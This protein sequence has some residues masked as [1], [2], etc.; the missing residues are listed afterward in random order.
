[1][2]THAA[3]PG[4][5]CESPATVFVNSAAGGGRALVYL[6]RIQK[7]FESFSISAQF[8]ATNSVAELEASAQNAILRGRRILFAMGGDGTFQ[9]LANA[10]FGSDVLLGVLPSG[11]GNDFAAAIGL[12]EDFLEA[13]EA[14]L[15]GEP[16]SVDLLKVRTAEGRTRLYVGG[17]GIGLDAEAAR[18]ASGAYRR[19][20]GRMRYIASALRALVWFTPL[21]IH[22]EF[23]E[24]DLFEQDTKVLLG[25]ALNTPTYG[26]GLRLAPGAAVDD[27]LMHVVLIEDIG[28]LGILRLLPRLM[29]S[30]ELRTSRVKRWHVKKARFTT[31]EPC[32]FHADGEIIGSTPVDIEVVPRA[33]QVLAPK[34]K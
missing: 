14:I 31:S 15:C 3:F 8:I 13:T 18:Y 24:S 16:R 6:S 9:A 20:P 11:G 17:G 28:A 19:F 7:L 29:G 27:G 2:S 34:P 1:M 30:G 21:E 25:A 32:M 23:P 4:L 22:L 33:I 5:L 12:P 26:A 10:A